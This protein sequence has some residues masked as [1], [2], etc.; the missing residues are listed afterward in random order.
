MNQLVENL[1]IKNKKVPFKNVCM[2]FSFKFRK[3]KNKARRQ[4]DSNL[5]RH[6]PTDFES[7]SL[8]TRTYRRLQTNLNKL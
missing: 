8:T 4:Q 2:L 7:V 1:I 3:K 6:S 5:R